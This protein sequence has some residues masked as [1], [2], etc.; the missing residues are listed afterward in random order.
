MKRVKVVHVATVDLSIR[1]LLLNQ[2]LYLKEKGFEVSAV[3]SD[4]KWVPEVRAAGIPVK[5]IEMKRKISP[6]SDIVALIKMAFYFRKERFQIVHTHTPK[7]GLLGQ[8]AAKL[9]RVPVI[10]NTIHG[11]YFHDNMNRL[12]RKFYIWTE[13]IAA[14]CSD[15]ILSQ[16]SEDISTALKERI[17]REGKISYLGNGVDIT[18]F[19]PALFAPLDIEAK[20]IEIGILKGERVVGFV[21]RLVKEKGIVEFF[22]AAKIVKR[23]LPKTKFIIIG[24]M[25]SGKKDAFNPGNIKVLDLESEVI[26]LGMRTDIPELYAVMDI[27]VLPSHREGFP[28]SPM[29]A[30]AMGK[31]VVATDIRG[32]RE[33]VANGE[34]GILVPVKDAQA[35]AEA[36]IYLLQNEEKAQEMGRAGRKRAEELFD[37]RKVFQRIESEY[38]RLLTKRCGCPRTA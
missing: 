8:L 3:C 24:P 10:V 17:C 12:S 4:G 19:D 37:E 23:C 11:F 36:I 30:A 29:E 22:E 26:F 15:T 25:E 16:N 20:K 34:T 35:L 28:R 31:P 21:G 32:C 33:A 7:A 38:Q 9:A 14:L 2:L 5:T 27:L 13:K 6:L 18:R 1:F